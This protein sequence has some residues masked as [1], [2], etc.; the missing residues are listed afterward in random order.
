MKSWAKKQT[1]FTI[2]ELLIVIVVIAI[3]AA[4]T[5]V[6]Y[7]GIQNRAYDTTVQ[8]DLKQIATKIELFKADSPTND[9]PRDVAFQNLNLSVSRNAYATSLFNSGSTE[10]NILYCSPDANLKKYTIIARSK[11]GN[12]FRN[13]TSGIGSY[14]MP[15][16][17]S[18]VDICADAG[19]ET[20]G[21]TTA[22]RQM[23]YANGWQPWVK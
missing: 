7:N 9:I 6:A 12:V 4:I 8:S 3:L 13:G 5:V 1:G 19:A 20:S 11:S 18:T 22:H 14:T 15:A 10:Y 16:S 23:F 21:A 17:S 2:V